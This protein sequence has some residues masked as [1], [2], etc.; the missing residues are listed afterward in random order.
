MVSGVGR[1]IELGKDA[2][3]V[4]LDR[5]SRYDELVCDVSVGSSLGDQSEDL[6]LAIC[7]IVDRVARSST[8]R[9][10]RKDGRI[11]RRTATGD[12]RYGSG[13]V[14]AAPDA[15]F[16][17]IPKGLCP[18]IVAESRRHVRAP[19]AGAFARRAAPV[20][21]LAVRGDVRQAGC[22]AAARAIWSTNS[23]VICLVAAFRRLYA[24]IVAIATTSAASCGSM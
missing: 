2:R 7:Q 21:P 4:A 8:A 24:L 3:D 23:P 11:D 18:F 16:Q 20:S 9:E 6:A 12:L 17:E 14:F 15:L 22:G 1:Q 5:G 19:Q 13:E 10:S